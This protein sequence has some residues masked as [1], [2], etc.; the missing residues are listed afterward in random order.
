M[1]YLSQVFI[2]GMGVLSPNGVGLNEYWTNT[3]NGISGIK[4]IDFFDTSQFRVK[5]GGFIRD[6]DKIT[7]S[8]KVSDN[9]Y[10]RVSILTK[11][12]TDEALTNSGLELKEPNSRVGIILG[13]AM[14]GM[15]SLETCYKDF[16][17]DKTGITIDSFISSMP[18]APSALLAME[19]GI[20]GLNYIINTACSSAAAAIGLAYLLIRMGVIDVCI[21]GGAEV[22]L[23]P[24]TLKN[25]EGLKILNSKSNDQPEKACK[26]FSKDRRGFVLSEG[27]GILILESKE[28]LEKRKGEKEC[29]IIGYGIT[30]DAFHLVAP[31]AKGQM[32]SISSALENANITPDQVDY[33]H[34]HGTAT[35]QNDIVETQIIKNIYGKRAYNIPISSIKSMV[36]HS[37]G[38]SAVLSIISTIQG[39]N[40]NF[41]HPTINLDTPD[42]ECD[43]DYIA[44]IGR[45]ANAK[46]AVVHSFGFGGTNNVLVLKK[47]D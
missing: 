24:C 37:L 2:S 29:E 40:H 28:H 9:L 26:P 13:I 15:R 1:R 34:A 31:D 8:H 36:G 32:M 12:A 46:I 20:K 42:P 6:L 14:G 17:V 27:A 47:I 18:N 43:L 44:N 21:A 33:I 25:F 30:D 19:Y 22:P 41:L 4:K 45:Y 16:F 5:I 23:T 7:F 35:K 3:K 11:I 39:L 10:D 38:A